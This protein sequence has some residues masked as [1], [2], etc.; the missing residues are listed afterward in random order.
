MQDV[1]QT[2]TPVEDK[3]KMY[4]LPK[5]ATNFKEKQHIS[6]Q[7]VYETIKNYQHANNRHHHFI[8]TEHISF[9]LIYISS[10]FRTPI[11]IWP[12]STRLSGINLIRRGKN[13]LLILF[14]VK[15]STTRTGWG[16]HY[17]CINM[18]SGRR[19]VTY[20]NRER[21]CYGFLLR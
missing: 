10:F 4:I 8:T 20:V 21:H 18:K 14:Y 9:D 1:D 17:I 13:S 16:C 5:V 19:A 12:R 2:T 15:Q 11:W 7:Q 3:H 6:C